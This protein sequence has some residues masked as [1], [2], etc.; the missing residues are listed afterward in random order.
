M[1]L[2]MAELGTKDSR[3]RIATDADGETDAAPPG[4]TQRLNVCRPEENAKGHSGYLTFC[5]RRVEE[6]APSEAQDSD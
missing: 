2:E 3:K 6:T 4:K 1:A 5:R